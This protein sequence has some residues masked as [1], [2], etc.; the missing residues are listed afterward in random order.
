MSNTIKGKV[1]SPLAIDRTLTKEN[2]CADAKATGD[3]IEQLRKETEET[4]QTFGLWYGG[5]V[6]SLQ[7]IC[8]KNGKVCTVVFDFTTKESINNGG[9]LIYSDLPQPKDNFV[10][11]AHSMDGTAYWLGIYPTDTA[12]KG[13]MTT[14]YVN[15]I[16]SGTRLFGTVTYIS[17]K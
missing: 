11:V 16:P 12:S 4:I 2:M 9:V 17:A 6:S 14:A 1:L 5:N 13:F 8:Y 10:F 15:D 7:H 3:A